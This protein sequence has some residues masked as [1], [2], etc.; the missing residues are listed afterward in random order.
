MKTLLTLLLATF[1][2]GGFAN[3]EK[4][5]AKI[6]S[7]NLQ[8][9]TEYS[10]IAFKGIPYA[11]PPVGDLRWRPPQPAA[12]W[13]GTRDAS[14]FGDSCP[15]PYLKNLSVDL[16]LPGNEDCLKLNVFTPQKPGKDLPVMVWIHGGGLLVDG[17][18]DSQFQPI[19]LVKNDVI[20][21]T[22]DYRLGALG[23]FANKELVAEAK[24][25]GEPVGNYG[26]MDQIAVLK[27]VKRNIAA[28]GGNPNN[29]TIFGESAGGR[30]VN[31][32]MTS[33]AARGL[34]HKAI[35]QSAEQ[36]PL[37]GTTEVRYGKPPLTEISANY[38]KTL[39]VSSLRELRALPANKLV[40]TADQFESGGFG[41]A[42]I[43]G[44]IIPGDPITLFA[45]GKQAKVPFIIGTNSWDSSLL[46][47]GQPP[48]ADVQ[49]MFNIA[50]KD[51]ERRYGNLKDKCILSSDILGDI[52]F[53]ASTKFLA[54]SM[55]GIAPGYAYY[56]DY[57]T[58]KIR[59]A[60][61]GTPHTFDVT[62]V[63]GSYPLMPQAP[64]AMESSAN[65][66]ATIEKANAE[67]KKSIWA[68][69]W[70]P[71]TDKNDPQ[72]KA[73]SEKMSASWTTFAKTGNPNV[74][75][76]ANWPIYNLKDDVM[77]HYSENSQTIT[78]MLKERVDYQMPNLKKLFDLK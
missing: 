6:E 73:M 59:P 78:G 67:M 72:D 42:S 23:F 54:N 8:G 55:N 71:I 5:T 49:K 77:R 30:S 19:G 64:K 44:Q 26:T 38:M 31:W 63:F 45:A 29:V 56:F 20:V 15:Q 52:V 27:W 47:P 3:T 33:E 66:C 41:G 9:T 43:D 65:R 1:A 25:K 37:R 61:P 51:F 68:K 70:F 40:L 21:V 60:Y 57:L 2:L 74:E 17:S 46:A 22:F 75:G 11:A 12:S 16:A 24:T 48:L 35:S 50:P 28:F 14:K 34:F 10:M 32:L 36:S 39:G 53:R 69:Y 4:P 76:Q 18:K 62:Y 58:P 7:G 13:T